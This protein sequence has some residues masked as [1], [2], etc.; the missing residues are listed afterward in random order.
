MVML[1][2]YV[3]SADEFLANGRDWFAFLLP[4][5]LVAVDVAPRALRNSRLA[6]RAA[7][8]VTVLL[9]CYAAVG[10][11]YASTEVRRRYYE[12]VDYAPTLR[13]FASTW[14][15]RYTGGHINY[16]GNND[17]SATISAGKPIVI[18]G[19]AVDGLRH[20]LARDVVVE[21]DGVRP[22]KAIY[23]QE[24]DDVARAVDP[25]YRMSGFVLTLPAG[26][27]SVGRHHAALRVVGRDFS[28][29]ERARP[30]RDVMLT[31]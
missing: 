12:N 8:F 22:I 18:L 5:I 31:P 2:L 19:W 28:F 4:F 1:A 11:F 15:G 7:T 20:S 14:D 23:N 6:F 26:T 17:G 24:R 29:Y 30:A 27:L 16:I 3:A 10:T 9:G 25:A 13:T 21:I